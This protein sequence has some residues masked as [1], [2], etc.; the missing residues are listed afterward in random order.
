MDRHRIAPI[1]KQ[2]KTMVS[3]IDMLIYLAIS[4]V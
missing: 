1:I 3:T 2:A 4:D